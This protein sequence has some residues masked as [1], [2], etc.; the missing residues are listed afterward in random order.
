MSGTAYP[1]D[2]GDAASSVPHVPRKVSATNPPHGPHAHVPDEAPRVRSDLT[3]TPRS[4]TPSGPIDGSG[5]GREPEQPIPPLRRKASRSLRAPPAPRGAAVGS[6]SPD[7]LGEVRNLPPSVTSA[8]RHPVVAPQAG[9]DLQEDSE[10]G[11][12]GRGGE[13]AL[14]QVAASLRVERVEPN[15]VADGLLVLGPALADRT[16]VHAQLPATGSKRRHR[17]QQLAAL[18]VT[19]RLVRPLLPAAKHTHRCLPFRLAAA[20]LAALLS[21]AVLARWH[22]LHID[23][24][25]RRVSRRGRSR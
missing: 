7:D 21:S 17:R 18:G 24:S 15:T 12:I 16:P 14:R 22:R 9:R 1:A 25:G 20:L 4:P 8:A 2:V 3:D 13:L 23:C 6:S 19:E 10:H 5:R 11:G